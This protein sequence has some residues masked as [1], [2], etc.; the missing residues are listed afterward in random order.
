M[1]SNVSKKIE[2]GSFERPQP[3][4]EDQ[5][6]QSVG[7]SLFYLSTNSS[8]KTEEQKVKCWRIITP[9]LAAVI[10]MGGIAYFLAQ[11]FNTLYPTDR[12]QP[13]HGHDVGSNIATVDESLTNNHDNTTAIV[14][15]KETAIKTQY[16][17]PECSFY[18]KCASLEG[19]CCP[20][21]DGKFL[22]CCH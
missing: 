16:R 6:S 12:V 3:N 19:L 10:I 9:I 14:D 20:S 1:T 4:V 13:Y 8:N 15:V 7:D 22:D 11:Y 5:V 2:Y 21:R 18:H 17:Y